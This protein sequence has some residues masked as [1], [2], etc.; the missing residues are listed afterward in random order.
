[1]NEDELA[2]V[3]ARLASMQTDG[4]Y[5]LSPYE[6]DR[7]LDEKTQPQYDAETVPGATMDDLDA[8]L[9]AA[10]IKR[11][12]DL[13][14][15][16]FAHETDDEIAVSFHIAANDG[17][18]LRPTL[19]GLLALG[20]YPQQ[21][22]PR[23]N[24]TFACYP[25][26]DKASDPQVKFLDSESMV[27][28]IPVM[29]DDTIAAVARNMRIGGVMDGY[30]RV[31][32]P[33]YPIAAV[34]EAVCNALMHRDYSPMARG[35]QV[36]VNLYTDRLEILSPGGLFGTVTPE[37]ITEVGYSSTRNQFLANILESTPYQGGFVAENRGTGFRLIESELARNGMRPPIVKDSIS[38]FS[39]TFARGVASEDNTKVQRGRRAGRRQVSS[40][41]C[42]D[43]Q[44]NR[45]QHGNSERDPR[46]A[47]SSDNLNLPTTP[48]EITYDIIDF[49]AANEPC[50]AS[51][52]ARALDIPRST[53]TYQLKKLT[54]S[55]TIE[56]LGVARSRNQKYRIA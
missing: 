4:D 49:I 36:Q 50:S 51:E 42:Q 18:T 10:V 21:Y 8:D 53:L 29:I 1:M 20:T 11:Q 48:T 24:V 52:I 9:L 23:L 33:D 32:A 46:G 43:S 5:R 31:D 27:G 30:K 17:G 12:R 16:V 14:P 40:N 19:A 15:R 34:R 44:Q 3:I 2:E 47:A 35:S 26:T 37:T 41:R 55:G 7:L 39:L 6:I 13:H 45:G 38:M 54:T 56:R 25:G 28:P 22:F